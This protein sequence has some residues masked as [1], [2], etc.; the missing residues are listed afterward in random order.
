MNIIKSKIIKTIKVIVIT[1]ISILF[2]M[3]ILPFLFP[4]TITNNVK[5]FANENLNAKLNFAEANLSFFTH[6]PSLTLTLNEFSLNGSAP[7]QNENLVK[8]KEIGFGINVKDLIFNKSTNIDKIFVDNALIIIKVNKKGEANYN[9]Y[10]SDKKAKKSQENTALKLSSINVLNSHLI[11]DDKTSRFLLD[12]N[13]FNYEGKGDLDKA[14]FELNT[15]A[16]IDDLNLDLNG[17]SYLK[18]KKVNA[19]LITKINTNSLAFLFQENKL[20]INKL[21][22]SFTGKFDFLSNG[23][24]IDL[25]I[26]SKK[27][28]LYDF[29]TALPPQY[30]TWL[31]KTQ[32][33]G[34]TDILLKLKGKYIASKSIKP[35]LDFGMKI[36]NGFVS[37]NKAPFPAS[38]VLMDIKTKLPSLDINNLKLNLDTIFLTVGKDF[39]AANIAS[40]GL[41]TP[42]LKTK[43]ISQIDLAKLN[44][45]L[46][47]NNI[48]VKGL[49]KINLLANGKYNKNIGS[50]PITNGTILL[51]NGLM[52]TPFYPKPIQNIQMNVAVANK[53]GKFQDLNVA[54]KPASFLFEGKPFLVNAYLKNFNDLEY[55]IKAKGEIDVAKIYKVFSKKGLDFDG[56]IKANV[57]LM[58]R[59]SD[60]EKGNYNRLK[61][62]GT[63]ALRNIKTNSEFLP[64]PFVI[65]FGVFTFNND[66]LNF[67]NFNATYGKSDL[68]M[69]GFMQNAI[70]FAIKKNA[71]LKGNFSVNSN[72]I[73]VNEFMFAPKIEKSESKPIAS[74]VK[75]SVVV[76]PKNFDLK[77][78]ANA[79]QIN[80]DDLRIENLNGNLKINK[81]K[82]NLQQT[83]FNIVGSKVKIDANYANQGFDKAKFDMNLITTDFDIKRAYKEVKL[84]REMVSVAE[85]A[86]GIA[87][88]DYKIEGVLNNE[89]FPVFPSLLGG[90]T[91]TVKNAKV[92]GFK[93][94]NAINQKTSLNAFDNPDVKDV[95]VKTNIKNNIIN[96]ERF[97]MK[98]AGFRPRIEG[99]TSFDGK[100]NIKMRL[101]LPPLGIIGIPITVTGNKD[102]PK[103][104]LGKKGE[105]IQE[106]EFKN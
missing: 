64:K 39:L 69:N 62:S 58:G 42:D 45:A 50:F 38:N 21:P 15:N 95:I 102:K 22:I 57:A 83:T 1:F 23:Y 40:S 70:N 44:R 60:T 78:V 77:L 101:G 56:F 13:G 46:G 87:S 16:K 52:K 43:I 66:K 30:V 103:I 29:F 84:I 7:F 10:I 80:F 93:M 48:D 32:I 14:I 33:K 27:S 100:F 68:K 91:F 37:H 53:T 89:M 88:L 75:K 59:Q 81:G 31:Q 12:A 11:Y 67:N 63:F 36:R 65:Q 96:I 19:N 54:I 94:F 72:F 90:G 24:D 105:D 74:N 5:N 106:T 98:V 47:I 85:Y 18:N 35:D 92:K 71:V 20:M 79:K 9:I 25:T 28:Q 97:K 55:N 8:A 61:N 17:E 49:M 26:D 76:I 6:F 41:K 73:D 104:K 99:Q 2:L 34:E 51:K 82:I 3:F 86:E 4:K